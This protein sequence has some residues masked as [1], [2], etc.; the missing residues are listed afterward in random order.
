MPPRDPHALVRAMGR[1]CDTPL[2]G[3]AIMANET[4]EVRD[5]IARLHDQGTAVVSLITDQPR[6]TRD[7]FVGIDNVAAGRTAGLLLGRFTANRPGNVAVVVSSMLAREMV[8][9]R[10]GFDRILAERF[11]HLTPLAS[12]EGHDDRDQTERAL[13]ACLA[14]HP[15]IVAVYSGGV[16]TSGVTEALRKAG[17][18][19]SLVVIGHELTGHTREALLDGNIDA[20]IA[21]DVGHIARSAVR[22]LRAKSDRQPI[23]P[24]QERIRIDIILR[25]NLGAAPA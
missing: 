25:E 18:G 7:H 11:P 20:V 5:L 13:S 2:D 10:L 14:V 17:R 3:C 8:E 12:L 4:A 9:R 21:Q 24:A 19:N 23:D 16:G 6:T 22:I 15:D 1:A